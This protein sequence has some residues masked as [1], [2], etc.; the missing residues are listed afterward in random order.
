MNSV[1]FYTGF[2]IGIIIGAALVM[3]WL[4]FISKLFNNNDD[5]DNNS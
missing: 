3:V 2:L 5:Q 4:Y 1:Y